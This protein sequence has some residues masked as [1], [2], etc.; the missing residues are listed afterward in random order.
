VC[1]PERASIVFHFNFSRR[2][3][4]ILFDSSSQHRVHLPFTNVIS[5]LFIYFF[6]LLIFKVIFGWGVLSYMCL[7]SLNTPCFL[8]GIALVCVPECRA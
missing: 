4:T 2:Q 1:I 8:K 5:N 7:T 6:N 3:R